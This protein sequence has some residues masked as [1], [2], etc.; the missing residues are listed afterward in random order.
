MNPSPPP[1]KTSWRRPWP[2]SHYNILHDRMNCGGIVSLSVMHMYL[3][4]MKRH[5]TAG[6]VIVVHCHLQDP[7]VSERAVNDLPYHAIRM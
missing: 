5:V 1:N 3:T 7:N 4:S 6:T 2:L